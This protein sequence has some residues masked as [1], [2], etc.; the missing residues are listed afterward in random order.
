MTI[1]VRRLLA[2][3]AGEFQALRLRGLQE[4]PS[5]FASSF[6]EECDRPLS[7]IVRRL[8]DAP[9]QAVFG[10][11]D[12]IA[13]AG[14]VGV[15]REA[16]AKLAHKAFVWGMYVAPEHRRHGVGL[17]LVAAALA[18]AYAMPGVV[19]VNLGVN[20]DNAPALKLYASAGFT[21]F[22]LERDFMRVDGVPQDEVHMVHE[23]AR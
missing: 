11:Y 17:A 18:H 23:R 13:L 7:S 6:A 10:A 8:A 20:A 14:V 15:Q 3:D 5:A 12:G 21:R 22:G 19:R 2:A 16:H 9:D 1:A 4:C